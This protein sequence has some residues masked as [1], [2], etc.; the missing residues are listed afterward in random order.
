M[1]RSSSLKQLQLLVHALGV[2]LAGRPGCCRGSRGHEAA[3]FTWHL[4]SGSLRGNAALV[5]GDAQVVVAQSAEEMKDSLLKGRSPLPRVSWLQVSFLCPASGGE[6]A[7]A[8]SPL[9]SCSELSSIARAL[10]CPAHA[11]VFHAGWTGWWP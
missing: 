5:H 11:T 2:A 1:L 7:G 6:A 10:V 9:F 8:S 4:S 3:L